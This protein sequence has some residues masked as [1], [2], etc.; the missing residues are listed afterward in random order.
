MIELLC[1]LLDGL[2]LTGDVNR[3]VPVFLNYH[4]RPK[5]ALHCAAVAAEARRI[6]DIVGV[7]GSPAE[8]GGWLHDV[9][10]VFSPAER[11]P[12]ARAL[13]IE[14][15]PE[16]EAFPFV[17]HQK[18]SAVMARELFGVRDPAVLGAV[19]CHT[20]LRTNATDLDKVVFIA[21][22][23]AWDQPGV[24]PYREELLAALDHSLDEAALCYL[25]Y[26]WQR[27]DTLQ[28]IHPWFRAAYEQLVGRLP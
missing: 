2:N 27:R 26:L 4:S 20:T 8:S 11:L 19:G 24:P 6:A 3:D 15:L 18:L 28:V 14:T 5:T 16:E 9:S 21:D 17:I 7:P 23:I 22:K 1:R 25:R 12:V 10:A 13:G